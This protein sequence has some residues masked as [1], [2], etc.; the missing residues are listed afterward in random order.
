MAKPKKKIGDDLVSGTKKFFSNLF[1]SSKKKRPEG[2]KSPYQKLQEK[3][4]ADLKKKIGKQPS[5]IQ[6]KEGNVKFAGGGD[7]KLRKYNKIE[8]PTSRP[9]KPAMPTPRPKSI[10]E[11]DFGMGQ[12]DNFK[13]SKIKQGPPPP[14]KK[15]APVKRKSKSNISNSS[16]YDADF[17]KKELEKRGL[18]AKNFMSKE[19]YAKTS[20]AKD[21]KVAK[22]MDFGQKKKKA[23]APMYESKGTMGGVKKSKYYS[24]GGTVFTGR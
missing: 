3:K 23:K 8:K 2:S 7:S 14:P 4:K 10:K 5:R 1:S 22:G 12:M 21:K 19:N 9:E 11:K 15:K 17:T 18:K 6:D 16:S 24:R 13:K 20:A